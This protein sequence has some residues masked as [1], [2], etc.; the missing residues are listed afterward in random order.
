MQEKLSFKYPSENLPDFQNDDFIILNKWSKISTQGGSKIN[1]SIDHIIKNINS[2]YRLVHRLDKDTT[3]LLIIAKNLKYAKYFSKLFKENKIS[4]FY[5][6]L[7]EGTPKN[8]ISQ[9]NLTIKNKKLK[10]EN[11]LTNYKLLNKKNGISEIL[12]NPKTGKT[13]QLRIVSKKLGC[14]II[15]DL[16]YNNSS[17]FKDD[18]LMLHAYG[19]KFAINN[20]KFDFISEIPNHFISFIKKNNFIITKNYK[21]K[22]DIF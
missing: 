11:T 18:N 6:A 16:K 22:L 13:H 15:G 21:K 14:P 9:I 17:K 7:C 3:G 10:T 2:N 4:K 19:L 5:I 1:I 12:Y 8:N 20:S